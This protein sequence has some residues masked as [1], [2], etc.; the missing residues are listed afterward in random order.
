MNGYLK[1]IKFTIISKLSWKLPWTGNACRSRVI[2]LLAKLTGGGYTPKVFIPLQP[3][4]FQLTR[5]I[6]HPLIQSMGV[7]R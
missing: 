6:Q 7:L 3:Y 5:V 4:A 2:H 1:S